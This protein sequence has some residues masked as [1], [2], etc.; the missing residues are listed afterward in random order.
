MAFSSR[1]IEFRENNGLTQDQLA[2]L[3]GVT[4]VTIVRWENNTSKPSSLAANKLEEIGFGSISLKETKQVSTPRIMLSDFDHSKLLENIRETIQVNGNEHHITPS[5]YVING[6]EDQLKFFETLYSLQEHNNVSNEDKYLR[7]LSSISSVE[8]NIVTAQYELEKPKKTAKHWNPKYGSHGWH[9][10]VGRFPSHLVRA[11]L[12]HFNVK[13]GDIVLD[14]F[15]GSG[16]TLVESRLLGL[17]SVGI[18]VCPL[19]SLISR[20]KSKFP[21]STS[22]LELLIPSLTNFYNQRWQRF[23]KKRNISEI[24]YEEILN[25]PGNSVQKFV[26]YEKWFSKQALLGVSIVV[27][28]AET[29]KGY[30]R[31]FVCC[32]LSSRMRSIGNVDVNVI[33]AEYSKNPRQDVDVL[34]LVKRLLVSMIRDINEMNKSHSDLISSSKNITMIEGSMLNADISKKSINYIITSPPYGVES[35]SYIRTHLL[36]YRSLQS[37]LKYDP[38]KFNEE[39]IGSEYIKNGKAKENNWKSAK[40]SSTFINFFEHEFKI[41]NKKRLIKRKFMMMQ[42]F[43]DMVSMA[44]KFNE[45]LIK[46]GRIAFVIG[47]KKIEDYIIPTDIIITEIFKSF[48]LQLDQVITHKLK[49]NN[50]NSEVPWQEKVIQD[51]FVM[52]FTKI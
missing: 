14:P 45:W 12:N 9:R 29:L 31:D 36:S 15:V 21:T 48:N 39:I 27:E 10:Y 11:L 28:F 13:A 40:Y 37:I 1:L 19:S 16:T 52:I 50:S 24:S 20:T 18:E 3:L 41:V 32:A 2:S 23:L 44:N 5:P 43:D 49:F 47:N 33:R 25:R 7:K 34:T 17:K 46:G 22:A 6:P 38:Y 4:K 26:N 30:D 42:F 35:L 8:P 51:E